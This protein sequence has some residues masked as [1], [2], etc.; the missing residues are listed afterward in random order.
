MDREDLFKEMIEIDKRLGGQTE[1]T[2]WNWH[3]TEEDKKEKN[4][5]S[6]EESLLE[7]QE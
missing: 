5:N 1:G 7:G 4:M 3:Q 2:N 6:T